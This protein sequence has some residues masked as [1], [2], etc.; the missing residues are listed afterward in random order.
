[1]VMMKSAARKSRTIFAVSSMP[2]QRMISGISAS[3]GI[4]RISSTIGSKMPRATDDSPIAKPSGMPTSA[5][6]KTPASTLST[7]IPMCSQSGTLRKPSVASR[8]SRVQVSPSG[9]Q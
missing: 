1:M 5:P 2:N 9:G 8:W 4:G 6:K 7:L 3:G